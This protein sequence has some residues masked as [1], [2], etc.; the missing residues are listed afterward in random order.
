MIDK[1]LKLM[2]FSRNTYFNWRKE[3][4]PVIKLIKDYFSEQDIKEFLETGQITKYRSVNE[5]HKRVERQ[6]TSLF[7]DIKETMDSEGLY[8]LLKFLNIYKSEL[9]SNINSFNPILNIGRVTPFNVF[10]QKK[11]IEFSNDK[12]IAKYNLNHDFAEFSVYLIELPF[13]VKL[14]LYQSFN[15]DFKYIQ[16]ED[17]KSLYKHF[18]NVNNIEKFHAQYMKMSILDDYPDD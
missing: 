15:T 12:E 7:K 9:L 2:G 5:Y 16:S 11:L 18:K 10:L 14:F 8:L 6:F 1:I 17:L 13:E 3:D 4:R